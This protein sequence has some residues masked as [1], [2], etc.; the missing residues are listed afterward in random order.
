MKKESPSTSPRQT[1]TQTDPFH[2]YYPVC[3]SPQKDGLALQEPIYSAKRNHGVA[4][5]YKLHNLNDAINDNRPLTDKILVEYCINGYSYALVTVGSILSSTYTFDTAAEGNILGEIGE[6]IARRITKHFLKHCNKRG[7]TGGIFDKRFD[8]QHRDD[9]IIA[10]TDEYI[11]K[12]L[13]YPNLL[14]LKKSGKG[15]YGYE[16]IKELDGF[17]D[18]RY[19]GKR[20]ILVLESKLDRLNVNCSDLIT[21]LFRPLRQLFPD[22][23]FRYILFS[24][25][26]AIFVRSTFDRWRQIKQMP[27]TIHRTL[28]KE[29]IGTLFFTFNENHGDFDKIKDFLILQ[30]RA[31]RN[32]SLTLQGKTLITDKEITIFDGGETPHIKLVKNATSGLWQEVP[33][34]HKKGVSTPVFPLN[35]TVS[36]SRNHRNK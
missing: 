22:A 15:H 18:Y 11:L 9:F 19:A 29:G 6:L 1:R 23:Q 35:R 10:H 32:L 7:K 25:R 16:S 26:N 27:V 33:L 21:N 13:K 20:H 28:E 17:F 8:P 14:I 30:F 24:D 31:L 5:T 4:G 3:W 2:E 34:R 12:I 36:V